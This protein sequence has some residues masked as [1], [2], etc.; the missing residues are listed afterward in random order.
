MEPKGKKRL[1]DFLEKLTDNFIIQFIL[2]SIICG[3]LLFVSVYFLDFFF[4]LF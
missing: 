1:Y 4:R 3:T 2:F